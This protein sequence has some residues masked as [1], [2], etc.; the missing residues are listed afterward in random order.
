MHCPSCL[1][2]S[3]CEA[4][5]CEKSH[6]SPRSSAY[7]G[8]SRH[9]DPKA[10]FTAWVQFFK[11]THTPAQSLSLKCSL[12]LSASILL[13]DGKRRLREIGAIVCFDVFIHNFD[14]SVASFLLSP[15]FLLLRP[16]SFLSSPTHASPLPRSHLP[17]TKT[18]AKTGCHVCGTT[19]ATWR[20]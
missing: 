3:M 17:C 7:S 19:K 9:L 11:H 20:T 12:P 16:Q 18:T 8:V 15:S 4:E 14:R 10:I 2:W 6:S 1:S 5:H 13:Q